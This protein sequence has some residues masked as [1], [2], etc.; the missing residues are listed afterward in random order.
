MVVAYPYICAIT[1]LDKTYLKKQLF[2]GKLRYKFPTANRIYR[3]VA[4]YR[5]KLS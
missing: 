2:I 3:V 1:V 4:S 5:I